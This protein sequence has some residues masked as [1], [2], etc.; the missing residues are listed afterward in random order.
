VLGGAETGA[1]QVA[2]QLT[3][4]GCHVEV[5]TKRTR[6]G[7][8]NEDTVDGIAVHRI[9]PGGERSAA[10]KW[11]MLPFAAASLWARR[12]RYDVICCVDYRGIGIAATVVGR[13]AGRPVCVQAETTGVLSVENWNGAL[14]RFGLAPEGAIARVLK[15][16]F[17]FLYGRASRFVCIARHIE[18]EALACG[19]PRDRVIYIPHGVD[20]E[21]FRPAGPD[22]R[23]R[24]R[25]EL[26]LPLDRLV[27]LYV[28]RLSREKGILDLLDAWTEV[29][30]PE[31]LLA[32][33]GPD[34]TGHPWDVGA[35]ARAVVASRGLA[36]RVRFL[37]PSAD[38]APLF[39]AADVF[40]QP[41]HFEAFG[42]SAIEA[43]SSG[44]AVVASSV[45]GMLDFIVDGENGLLATPRD[46]SDF[47][48]QI[49]RVLDDG[50][51]RARLAL[52]ARATVEQGFDEKQLFDR[53]AALIRD[54]AGADRR[55]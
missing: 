12:H 44:L 29:A 36:D 31:A 54:L 7:L 25:Q 37:G 32:V 47:A 17:R 30:H 3:A 28:G 22:E 16:P 33:V 11:L 4:R 8:P 21:R 53:Y 26:G 49:R 42:I 50:A 39:R 45:G 23:A 14:A 18:D 5:V 6:P 2:T 20:V 24:L 27:C 41:S 51:L 1:R 13:L 48:R 40:V 10:G 19:I 15:F 43:M 52:A 34:M 46:P 9:P 38:P 55:P 35:E